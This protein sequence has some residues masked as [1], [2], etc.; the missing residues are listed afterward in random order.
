VLKAIWD[1]ARPAVLGQVD[2]VEAAVTDALTGTLSDETRARAAREAHKL[3]GSVGTLGF[4]NASDNARELEH[5]L[6]GAGPPPADLPRLADLVIALRREL[7]L[8]HETDSDPAALPCCLPEDG[9]PALLLVDGDAQRSTAF[10]TAAGARD[11]RV[12]VAADLA[13]AREMLAA[14]PPEIVVLDLSI[15]ASL[16]AAL[17]SSTKRPPSGR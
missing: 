7:E 12:A 13:S 15:G 17:Q 6:N 1:E 14:Q 4:R 8:E 3:A 11:I 5:A 2:L 10:V 9:P 16:E